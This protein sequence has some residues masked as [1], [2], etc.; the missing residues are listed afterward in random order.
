M[1]KRALLGFALLWLV[2]AC[3]KTNTAGNTVETENTVA[4]QV[5]RQDGRPASRVLAKIRPAWYVADTLHSTD[6]SLEIRNVVTDTNG[7][8]HCAGLPLGRYVV[9][10]VGDSIGAANEVDHLDT[11]AGNDFAQIPL[12]HMG[13]LQGSVPLPAGVASAWV[14]IYGLDHQ[15]KTDSLGNFTFD[16]LPPGVVRIRAIAYNIPSELADNL[17]QIRPRFVTD[18]GTL[19]VP[20]P[21]SEDPATWQYSTTLRLDSL[22]SSWAL[23]VSDPTVI[24]LFLDSSNFPFA[25]AML[26]GRDLRLWDAQG[27][28]LVSQRARWDATLQKAV[29][30]VRVNTAGLDSNTRIT[31]AWGHPGAIELGSAGLWNGIND[32]VKQELYSLLIDDFEHNSGQTALPS[33]IPATYW[34]V[35]ADSADTFS[36]DLSSKYLPALQLAGDGRSGHALHLSYSDSTS[37]WNI[38]GTVFGPG[39]R[40]IATLDSI[41]F[42]VRGSGDFSLSFDNLSGKGG[43]AWMHAL[44]DTAWTRKCIRPQDLLAADSNADNVGWDNVKDVV[45]N[46]TFFF[47]GGKDFWIDDIRMYGINR[48]NL[49]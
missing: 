4:F 3:S 10:I 30:R 47:G 45:T 39:Q 27:N 12:F 11:T 24:T 44:L 35:I 34:Y 19:S 42:W 9:E 41:V 5:V 33:P 37:Q 13:S 46:L 2:S 26:D 31:M 14:Q 17:V 6:T 49:K 15:V 7:W 22:I 43:K 21:G 28:L 8:I 32:S 36:T 48:D 1:K 18:V 20:S 40:S 29:V 16:T 25:Q 38:L 23:P